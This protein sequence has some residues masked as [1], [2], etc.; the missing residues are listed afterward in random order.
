[1][2]AANACPT[3]QHF[4][5]GQRLILLVAAAAQVSMIGQF[6]PDRFAY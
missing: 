3:N 2:V 5:N 1:M 4:H 6:L